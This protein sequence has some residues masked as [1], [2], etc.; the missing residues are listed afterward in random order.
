MKEEILINSQISLVFEKRNE[1][2]ENYWQGINDEMNNVFDETPMIIPVPNEIPLDEVPVVQMKSSNGILM[3]NISRS[4]VD[5]YFH[6]NGTQK[7]SEIKTE[8]LNKVEKITHFFDVKQS[9]KIKRIGFVSRFFIEDETQDK[10]ISM[11]LDD[12]FKKIHFENDEDN[13]Y[14]TFIRYVNRISLNNLDTNNFTSIERFSANIIDYG[15]NIPGV[16]IT[17]DFN[18]SPENENEYVGIINQEKVKT[19][20]ELSEQRFNLNLFK[21]L[22]WPQEER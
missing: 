21:E 17:R 22:L 10:T 5:F 11:I 1:H 9:I 20:I 13:T 12:S 15:N 14:R 3:C 8:F 18:T 16:L 6:G 7:Y 4:R 19:F 2:P